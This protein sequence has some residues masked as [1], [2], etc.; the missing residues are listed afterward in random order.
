MAVE[1]GRT[2]WALFHRVGIA[3]FH[4]D[5]Y[6][7]GTHITLDIIQCSYS[8]APTRPHAHT[9]THSTAHKHARTHVHTRPPTHTHRRTRAR[10]HAH[11]PSTYSRAHPSTHPPTQSHTSTQHSVLRA[12]PQRK[13]NALIDL[14]KSPYTESRFAS[15]AHCPRTNWKYQR[16]MRPWISFAAWR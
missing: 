7:A 2:T 6:D 5:G 1:A 13:R 11:P 10:A 3:C 14:Q 16:W 9:H 12:R 15:V 8:L 4:L